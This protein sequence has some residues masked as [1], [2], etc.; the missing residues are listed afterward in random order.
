MI[1]SG[2]NWRPVSIDYEQI[3]CAL[4][5]SKAEEQAS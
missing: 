1:T 3:C 4:L 2:P 5:S